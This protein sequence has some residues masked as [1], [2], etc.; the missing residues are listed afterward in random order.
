MQQVSQ[1]SDIRLWCDRAQCL[2]KCIQKY[3]RPSIPNTWRSAGIVAH[4]LRV[5]RHNGQWNN[6]KWRPQKS[7]SMKRG[8]NSIPKF[9]NGMEALILTR[10]EGIVTWTCTDC[11][12]KNSNDKEHNQKTIERWQSRWNK[13][14]KVRGTVV[15]QTSNH[16]NQFCINF[17]CKN[18]HFWSFLTKICIN[19]QGMDR[20]D[21]TVF[22][23][24]EDSLVF[25]SRIPPFFLSSVLIIGT[26]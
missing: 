7:P 19:T 6:G 2:V 4:W 11:S 9:Q 26:E 15:Y 13:C 8:K 3:L 23:L 12:R 14:V 20:Y 10:D 18:W 24:A 25:L 22:I 21:N 5:P 17:F 1:L 16:S